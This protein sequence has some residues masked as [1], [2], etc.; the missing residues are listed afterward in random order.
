MRW[1]LDK[2]NKSYAVRI[3]QQSKAPECPFVAFLEGCREN[4][5]MN[6]TYLGIFR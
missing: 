6:E 2:S 1:R 3:N 5:K 4:N